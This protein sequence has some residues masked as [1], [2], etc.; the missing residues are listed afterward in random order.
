M[1]NGVGAGG[2]FQLRL[3]IV[4]SQIAALCAI[5]KLDVTVFEIADVVRTAAAFPVDYIAF[6]NRGAYET[7]L[8]L[9][10]NNQT[11]EI[12]AI[13]IFEPTFETKDEGLSFNVEAIKSGVTMPWAEAGVPEFPTA[14]HDLTAAVRYP[15]RTFEHCRMAVEV[16]RRHFDPPN[17]RGHRERQLAGER[18]MSAALHVTRRS[19]QALDAVAARSRHGELMFS[20]NWELRKRALEFAWE[21]VSRF[22]AH[23]QGTPHHQWKLL[24]VQFEK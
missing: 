21:L 14:L 16:V 2:R 7:V 15:R 22:L 10:I 23:L 6:L 1:S 13:P 20:I 12:A 5:E 19:L 4:R 11:G 17:I 8:D 24:D 18:N 3:E 9:C